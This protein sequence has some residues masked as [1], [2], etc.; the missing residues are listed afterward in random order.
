VGSR[1]EYEPIDIV[2]LQVL[3]F[4]FLPEDGTRVLD[5]ADAD[6]VGLAE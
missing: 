5:L 1:G 4:F 6:D 3:H 2:L